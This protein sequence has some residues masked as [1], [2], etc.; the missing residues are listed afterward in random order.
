MKEFLFCTRG[1]NFG[2][3]LIYYI[4]LPGYYATLLIRVE[5][6]VSA[7]GHVENG[8]WSLTALAV[9]D[10]SAEVCSVWILLHIFP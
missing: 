5:S 6:Q 9:M 7:W 8:S 4:F 3:F 10:S 2:A 1:R